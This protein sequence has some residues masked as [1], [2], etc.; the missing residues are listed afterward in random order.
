MNDSHRTVV[1]L[2]ISYSTRD[3]GYVDP[4]VGQLNQHTPRSGADYVAWQ[5]K[6]QLEGGVEWWPQIIKAIENCNA[7]VFFVSV[8]S[9][10]SRVC[11]AELA[12]ARARNRVI[13]PV[14]LPE[15][16]TSVNAQPVVSR[17]VDALLPDWMRHLQYV[18]YYEDS[19][20]FNRFDRAT[21]SL[22]TAT[23]GP[24]HP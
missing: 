10:R 16:F 6:H 1:N 24:L 19:R 13:I 23:H 2:F 18:F 4:I 8:Y 3:A 5:D 21:A 15:S 14:F 17:D 20:F 7:L 12:Y 11:Q 22:T 9:L